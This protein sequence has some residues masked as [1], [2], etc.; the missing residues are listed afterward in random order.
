MRSLTESIDSFPDP[1]LT[2]RRSIRPNGVL[3]SGVLVF[4]T[5]FLSS[6]DAF[7][8]QR[9]YPES[10]SRPVASAAACFLH[11]CF[12]PNLLSRKSLQVENLDLNLLISSLLF[13]ESFGVLCTLN[14]TTDTDSGPSV[15]SN[16]RSMSGIG[17]KGFRSFRVSLRQST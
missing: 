16:G 1:R 14:I 9:G 10:V 12:H 15:S 7:G 3:V 11:R 2:R 4:G 5:H 13:S 6:H 8:D 17:G